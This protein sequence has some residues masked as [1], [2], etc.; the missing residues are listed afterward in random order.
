MTFASPNV[1]ADI[2]LPQ[3][4]RVMSGNAGRLRQ[5]RR[6]RFVRKKSDYEFG[7]DAHPARRSVAREWHSRRL[8]LP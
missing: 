4:G 8:P 6:K 5:K 7:S 2:T 1:R 3:T